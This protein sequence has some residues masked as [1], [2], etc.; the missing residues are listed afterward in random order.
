MLWMKEWEELKMTS[1]LVAWEMECMKDISDEG[2]MVN[3]STV[4]PLGKLGTEWSLEWSQGLNCR[5]WQSLV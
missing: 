2:E 1:R 4:C 5:V 3:A